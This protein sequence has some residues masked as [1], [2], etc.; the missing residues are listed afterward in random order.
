MIKYFDTHAHLNFPE[1]DNDREEVILRSL[2]E[3]IFIINVGTSRKESEAAIKIAQKNEKGVFASVGLHPLYVGEQ[4]KKALDSE[5]FNK[6]SYINLVKESGVVAIGEVGL[7]YQWLESGDCIRDELQKKKQKEVL[8]EQMKISRDFHL[9]L[10]IHCRK[11]HA[12]LISILKDFYKNQEY[13]ERGVIHCFTGGIEEMKEYIRMGF[14]I[15][16]NGIIFKMNLAKVIKE[17]PLKMILLETDS[18]FL[19]PFLEVG[20]N[21]PFFIKHIAKEVAKIKAVGVDIVARETTENAVKLFNI[22]YN[23]K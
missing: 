19:S 9:P 5:I 7:D 21:E 18:P 1:Y 8:L 4:G 16:I 3:Y 14:Y 12:D 20:R 22:E 17:V 6:T 13:Q 15:G 11:A 23:Q 10:I 2:E